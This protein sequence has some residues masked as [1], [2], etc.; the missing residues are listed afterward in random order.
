MIHADLVL[1]G[2]SGKHGGAYV[3]TSQIDR[4]MN[5]KLHNK[6]CTFARFYGG[7]GYG[8]NYEHLK[9]ESI[10]KA[11]KQVTTMSLL[12]F[13]NAVSVLKNPYNES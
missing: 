13:P 4:E 11:V 6:P 10:L 1:L 12:G 7:L 5:L 3:E 8:K 9:L 2:S